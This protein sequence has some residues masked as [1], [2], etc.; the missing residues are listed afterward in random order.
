MVLKQRKCFR[1][2]FWSWPNI[3][4]YRLIIR[5]VLK[6]QKK[7]W[8]S[9]IECVCVHVLVYT[10]IYTHRRTCMIDKYTHVYMQIVRCFLFWV[11][12]FKSDQA[13]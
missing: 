11:K 8:R 13:S 12:E 3:E 4:M 2:A 1:P 5:K 6:K 9:V 7:F 10:Y